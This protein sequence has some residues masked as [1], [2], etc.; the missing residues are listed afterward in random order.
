MATGS[1][2]K[3]AKGSW[4]ARFDVPD[5]ITG[6]RKQRTMTI[7]GTKTEAEKA[8]REM[9]ANMDAGIFIKSSRLTMAE[10]LRDWLKGYAPS[11]SPATHRGYRTIVEFH[12][13][14][15]IGAV[16]LQQLH[17]SQI[18]KMYGEIIETG[19]SVKTAK[20]VHAVLRRALN[21]AVK[22]NLLARNPCSGVDAPRYHAPEMGMLSDQQ[23]DAFLEEVE[24][25]QFREALTLLLFTGLRRGEL[26]GLRWVDVNLEFMQLSVVQQLQRIPVE[27][28]VIRPPKTKG[29]KRNI[30]LLPNMCVM[31]RNLKDKKKEQL[32]TFGAELKESSLIFGAIDG[33]PIEP[34]TLTHSCKK[35]MKKIGCAELRLH[36]LRHSFASK[37]LREGVSIKVVQQ[38]MGHSSISTTL[39]IY[40]HITPDMEVEAVKKLER[41][42][43]VR[44]QS[45]IKSVSE[46]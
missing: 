1:L 46:G 15:K 12:L 43:K 28:W 20:N 13:I 19:A 44:D 22:Q 6:Q 27:G 11:L 38:M 39:G 26:L 5:P 3:R 41:G 36:D 17:P 45:V 10:Y 4:T 34:S 8:L 14:P 32:A 21:A 9:L 16:P 30:P 2:K 31:L 18:N 37:L 25:S 42:L 40:G 24:A 35:I 29:S 7:H 33:T 23:I